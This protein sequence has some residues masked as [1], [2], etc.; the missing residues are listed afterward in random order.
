MNRH[1]SIVILKCKIYKGGCYLKNDVSVIS[2][3]DGI[4]CGRLAFDRAGIKVGSYKAF[5]IDKYAK[6]I[7]R[8]NYPDIKQCGDVLDTDF[9]QFAGADFV[10]GGSPC[11]FWSIAKNNRETDKNGIG[12]ELFVKFIEA[13]KIVKPKY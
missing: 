2:L 10:I 8:Y 5:E 9:S 7:S 11:T 4:S 12:W 3:F 6:A 1:K 13:V